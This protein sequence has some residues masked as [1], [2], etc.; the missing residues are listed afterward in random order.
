MANPRLAKRYAKSL[1]DLSKEMGKLEQVYNDV[2]FLQK[3]VKMSRPFE[4]ML[5]SPIIHA[6][7][8]Y[9]IISSVTGN[10]ISQI[11]SSFIRL[12]CNKG[13][14]DHLSG[15]LTSFIEQY[16][17]LKGIHIAKL[18]TAIPVSD[19]IIRE[20]ESKIKSAS[21]VNEL[22]L[23]TKVDDSLI[24]GFVLEM[25]GMLI[26][27]SISKDLKDVKKQFDNNEYLHKLR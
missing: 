27:G 12:L 22:R 19:S 20:F 2:A 26:D 23:E 9:K 13:R 21:R 18:T 15:I 16:N 3:V 1:L 17:Q 24:G 6:D 4:I 14:E 25:E 10:N 5:D 8:K 7:K 11:T